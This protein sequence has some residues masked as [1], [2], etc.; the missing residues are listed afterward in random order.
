MSL[1]PRVGLFSVCVIAL[2]LSGCGSLRLYSDTRDKQG[3]A[4]KKAWGEVDLKSIITT[5]RD[6][7]KKLLEAE[8]ETQDQVALAMR[9][10][11]LGEMVLS[12]DSNYKNLIVRIRDRR[13]SVAENPRRYSDLLN[14]RNDI[15]AKLEETAAWFKDNGLEPLTCMSISSSKALT[16]AEKWAKAHPDTASTAPLSVLGSTTIQNDCTDF[17]KKEQKLIAE[18]GKEGELYTAVARL[19]A[20]KVKFEGKKRNQHLLRKTFLNAE[21]DYETAV[22]AA[23]AHPSLLATVAEKAKNLKKATT[24]LEEAPDSFT[25]QLLSK[26]RLEAIDEFLKVVT[27]AKPGEPPPA[28][29]SKAA[30]ATVLLANWVDETN[31]ATA[32]RQKLLVAPLILRKNYEAL[33]LE[34]ANRDI[35][36]DE[37][38]IRIDEEIVAVLLQ[39]GVQLSDAYVLLTTEIPS[40]KKGAAKGPPIAKKYAD[41]TLQE[42]FSQS[43]PDEK[44]RLYGALARYFDATNRLYARK[45]KLEYARLSEEHERALAYAEVNIKQWESLIGGSVGQLSAFGAGGIKP[46]HITNI[47][48]T[49]GV[50]WI[51]YG[52]NK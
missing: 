52:V 22:A 13:N 39:Q 12:T 18:I 27:Q 38:V 44:E 1:S 6:N 36:A 9:D 40:S 42:T 7:L 3:E 19:A 21:A 2:L 17:T 49:I 31:A 4:A 28:T 26:K 29:A 46:E 51:G 8:M 41:L 47:L 5:E 30:R 48:N 15:A 11:E 37:A 23:T 33:N 32:E 43:T 20:D 16:D 24:D 45:Q 50:L 14:A 34:A 35:A 10:L 25:N